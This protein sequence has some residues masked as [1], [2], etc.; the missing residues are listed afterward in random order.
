MCDA[1]ELMN[2]EEFDL[3]HA[4]SLQ[5]ANT[6]NESRLREILGPRVSQAIVAIRPIATVAALIAIPGFGRKR[7][8]SARECAA[9]AG[10]G[11]VRSAREQ[12][13]DANK[14]PIP[15]LIHG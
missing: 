4:P 15:R 12:V 8:K 7:L 6:A 11:W 13:R 1:D 3:V 10:F 2:S 5:W 9:D 14:L